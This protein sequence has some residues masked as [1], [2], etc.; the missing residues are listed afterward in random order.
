ML[1]KRLCYWFL[2]AP[3][4]LLALPPY[5]LAEECGLLR[6]QLSRSPGTDIT[7]SHCADK[8]ELSID[9]QVQMSAGGRFWLESLPSV[10]GGAE[11][12]IICQNNSSKAITLKVTQ[13]FLPWLQP[14]QLENCSTWLDNR[15]ICGTNENSSK[16]LV[17]AIAP[18]KSRPLAAAM[19]R[20]N[21]ITM[22]GLDSHP[23]K[24]K[25]DPESGQMDDWLVL[26]KSEIDLCRIAFQSEQTLTLSWKINTSGQVS[27]TSIKESGGNTKFA[28]CALD[29][30]K[31]FE[32]P[33]LNKDTQITF[34]F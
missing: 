32:F 1:N 11:F 16:N 29:A 7:A 30:I 3:G 27:E 28:D 9:S 4:L 26:L 15:L 14:Q 13:A 22:R 33:A 19:E 17:C 24:P 21:A 20:K 10:P 2:C 34:S 18:K 8:T 5:S 12:Q 23:H 6:M 25:A 31:S